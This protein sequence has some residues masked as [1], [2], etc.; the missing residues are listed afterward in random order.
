MDEIKE[1]LPHKTYWNP[2]TL[3]IEARKYKHK[4]DF[5]KGAPGAYY[6]ASN[7]G[8]LDDICKHMTELGDLY[9]RAI[10]AWEFPDKTVYV[11]LTDNIDRRSLQHMNDVNSP[12]YKHKNKTGLSPKFVLKS[13][14]VPAELARELEGQVLEEY[15]KDGWVKLNSIK[16]GGLGS[17]HEKWNEKSIRELAL[18]CKSR[19][20]FREKYREAYSKCSKKKLLHILNDLFPKGLRVSKDG[21]TYQYTQRKWTNEKILE[22]AAKYST[23]TELRIKARKVYRAAER[24]GLMETIA[25]KY[26]N[27]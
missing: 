16:T 1:M 11:G 4:I 19:K 26:H 22:E 6:A 20:E 3:E 18:T 12:V 17:V 23:L 27:Q 10:Y 13:G 2:E 14:Y 25:R 7:L 5:L 8:I 24:W 15:L 21:E 9:N